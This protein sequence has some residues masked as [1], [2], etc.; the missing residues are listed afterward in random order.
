MMKTELVK[1]LRYSKDWEKCED[2][3]LWERAAHAGWK[4]TNVPEVLL[5]YRQH[6]TQIS[7][8]TSIK[9][10]ELGQQVRR[11]Y[12]EFVFS[13]MGL[14]RE[15]ID[16]VLKL[17]E[18]YPFKFDMDKIDSVFIGLLEQNV[19]EA[20][21]IVFDHTTRL[22][23]RAAA[24]CPDAVARWSRLNKRFGKGPAL[25]TKFK[26][27][28]LSLFRVQANGEI[29]MRLKRLYFKMTRYI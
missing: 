26:L 5:L 1:Q 2:Y 23:F 16:E 21:A 28:M 22:Y 27:L 11:R 29:F 25:G 13:S 17:R 19:G 14:N 6:E 15:W 9:Q 3:D 7:T 20:Q 24:E 10:Q 18:P 8:S 4:M 12:W